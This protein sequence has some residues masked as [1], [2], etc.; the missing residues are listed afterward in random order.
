MAFYYVSYNYV[1]CILG[2]QSH[3]GKEN[4][5]VKSLKQESKFIDFYDGFSE[6]WRH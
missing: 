5:R 4:F 3:C 6:S 2:A 1:V